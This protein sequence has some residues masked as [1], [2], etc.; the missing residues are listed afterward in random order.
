MIA[1][2]AA[3]KATSLNGNRLDGT[4]S[5]S[6][7][8]NRSSLV[9]ERLYVGYLD[10]IRLAFYFVNPFLQAFLANLHTGDLVRRLDA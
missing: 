9:I 10:W 5:Y 3:Q 6:Q 8:N 1:V 4:F 2:F 7:G